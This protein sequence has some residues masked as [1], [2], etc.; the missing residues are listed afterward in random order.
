[1]DG[2]LVKSGELDNN[3][4][5]VTWEDPFKKPGYLFALVAGDLD[6]I[7]DEFQT[8]SGKIVDLTIYSEKENIDKCS[9]A[10]ESLKQ[11]MEWDEKRFGLE[12][13]LN[14]YQIVA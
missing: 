5:F 6:H 12:Y 4:H 11:A 14:L 3:R 2:N 9:H 10:M 13:D 1:M 7:K 8:C